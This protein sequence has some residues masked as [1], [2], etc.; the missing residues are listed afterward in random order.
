MEP[1]GRRQVWCEVWHVEQRRL[2]VPQVYWCSRF[3]CKLRGYTGRRAIAPDEGLVLVETREG[4]LNTA[5]HMLFVRCELGVIWLDSEGRIVDLA[6][7]RPWQLQL[8]P[9]KPARY[10]LECHLDHLTQVAI[11]DRLAFKTDDGAWRVANVTV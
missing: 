1:N 11:G 8:L 3:F 9:R 4:R 2:L 6:R 7:A 5:I 10:V